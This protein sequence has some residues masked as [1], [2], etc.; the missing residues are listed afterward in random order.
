M[1]QDSRFSGGRQDDIA[2]SRSTDGGDTWSTPVKV[3]K[4]TNDAA[5]FTA[6]VHVRDDG[7]VA[8]T[9]YDFR[10]DVN[11]DA[12]LDTDHWMV[13]AHDGGANWDASEA[14]L[15][16]DSFDM[17]TA[18]YAAG[19]FVGDYEGLDNAGNAFTPLFVTANDGDTAN[20]TDVLFRTAG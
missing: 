2:F 1:W 6:A 5:A 11:G 12:T 18:P 20:R 3:N 13:H 10:N 14:R 19:Y 9:Y 4:T 16:P 7:T 17:R 15:T 8:V